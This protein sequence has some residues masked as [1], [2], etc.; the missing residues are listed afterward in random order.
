MTGLRK[1]SLA[2]NSPK[3]QDFSFCIIKDKEKQQIFTLKSEN[4]QMLTFL[5]KITKMIIK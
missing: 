1:R 2:S 3:P 5:L 4:E